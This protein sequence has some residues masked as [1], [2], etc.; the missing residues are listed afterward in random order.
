MVVTNWINLQYY[1]SVTDNL[2]YGSG[3][4]LLHNVVGG[5]IGVFEG[6]SGDLRGGLA[7]QSV[8]DGQQWRHQPLRLS[9]YI[10]APR[11][12]IARIVSQHPHIADLVNNQWL[13]LFQV[14]ESANPVNQCA[15]W[16][17]QHNQWQP[18]PTIE[19]PINL[20]N[21]K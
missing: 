17:W 9:V 7:I 12:E 8:H 14:D 2:K 1:A 20:E 19:Y 4:K 15:I 11:E 13:F 10:A 18:A 5:H 21:P 16:Q 3:N 6:N